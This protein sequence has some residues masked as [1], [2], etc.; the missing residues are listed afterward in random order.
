MASLARF[1]LLTRGEPDMHLAS[2]SRRSLVSSVEAYVVPDL[3]ELA[4]ASGGVVARV[5]VKERD[6]V[7]RGQDLLELSGRGPSDARVLLRSSARGVVSHC[8][9]RVG[10][11]V[12][13]SSPLFSIARADDV[14]VVA[15]F[16]SSAAPAL[17]RAARAFVRVPRAAGHPLPASLVW[18]GGPVDHPGAP[19]LDG[20]AIRVVARL[21]AAPPAVMW[22]G[23]E[24]VLVVECDGV[25]G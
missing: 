13:R 5:L 4:S 3:V 22:P 18:V 2:P 1:D 25:A 10:D 14:L 21:D 16:E 24:A 12:D 19:D 15:R 8:H 9:V 6:V 7:T 11:T 20:G 23:I 17:R